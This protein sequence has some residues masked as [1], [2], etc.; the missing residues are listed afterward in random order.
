[1]CMRVFV[2]AFACILYVCM[3]PWLCMRFCV[4]KNEL[5]GGRN[6]VCAHHKFLFMF[7]S[8]PVK[9]WLDCLQ[10]R[11]IQLRPDE[12]TML[13]YW[14]TCAISENRDDETQIARNWLS[15]STAVRVI[16]FVS[17]N[18]A[19][20]LLLIAQ[21]RLS[22]RSFKALRIEINDWWI[23][24]TW[25]LSFMIFSF[26]RRVRKKTYRWSLE[27]ILSWNSQIICRLRH[28]SVFS[29]RKW[30]ESRKEITHNFELVNYVLSHSFLSNN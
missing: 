22:I 29:G 17:G 23:I 3:W 20:S 26:R 30:N 24:P 13:R 1:M 6:D 15:R 4:K 2:Y 9:N 12:M 5:Q 19:V 18:L 8:A 10:Y 28:D 16:S 25:V 7:W 11:Y 21:V 27:T 14:F